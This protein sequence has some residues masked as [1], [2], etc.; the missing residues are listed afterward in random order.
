MNDAYSVLVKPP[1]EGYKAGQVYYLYVDSTVQSEQGNYL[2]S[3]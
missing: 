3:L 2:R 1:K